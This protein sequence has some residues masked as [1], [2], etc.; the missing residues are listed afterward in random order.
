MK[1][2][3]KASWPRGGELVFEGESVQTQREVKE[4]PPSFQFRLAARSDLDAL[5]EAIQS[6]FP[7]P[8]GE[9]MANV[10]GVDRDRYYPYSILVATKAVE[11]GM[12][13]VCEGDD[14]KILGFCI[15]EDYAT[16]PCYLRLPVH[17]SMYPM[18]TLLAELDSKLKTPTPLERGQVFHL[19]MLGVLPGQ[20]GNGLG[21]ELLRRSVEL[22]RS[23]GFQQA[24]AEATGPIS[25]A[26]S[27]SEGFSEWEA[28]EYVD[29][30]YKGRRVFQSLAEATRC[31][32]VGQAF[33]GT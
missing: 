23:S 29:F 15:N 6:C 13:W 24:V 17:P 22:G 3:K 4:C 31:L 25:Q 5:V 26:I 20:G 10:L 1:F 33:S 21:R 18:L 30:E 9:V 32:L 2:F 27:L 28:I 8:N 19:Y 14:G 16:A 7:A 12:S 11:E